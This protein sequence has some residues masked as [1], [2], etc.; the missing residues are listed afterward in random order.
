[1]NRPSYHH[2]D[3]REAL[4][5]AADALVAEKGV[6]AFSLREAARAVGV[7]PAA[8]YRHFRDKRS[9]VQELARRGFTRLA[10]HMAQQLA[11]LRRRTPERELLAL[12]HAYVDFA[13]EQRSS[14]Q[15]MFGPTGVDARDQLLR[16]SYP[17]GQ[18]PYELLQATLRGWS[19][20]MKGGIDVD[21]ASVVLWSGVH[22][23]ACLLLDGALRPADEKERGRLVEAVLLSMLRG[24]EVAARR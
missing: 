14:F 7:D 18:G 15:V 21:R 13:V 9:V 22:G 19:A 8:C 1:M 17:D 12:G 24:L 4:L 11:R 2:G 3:L 23:I 6:A 10:A 5:V 20:T 16:G